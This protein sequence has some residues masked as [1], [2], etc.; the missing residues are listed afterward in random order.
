MTTTLSLL[1]LGCTCITSAHP[2]YPRTTPRPPDRNQP[3]AT[4]RDDPRC[5]YIQAPTT[6]LSHP[7][8]HLESSIWDMTADLE[9]SD[10]SKHFLQRYRTRLAKENACL[11]ELL[12]EEAQARHT[13]Q[14][15]KMDGV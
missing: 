3:I 13:A 4:D 9:N 5:A 8:R 11:A 10:G 6:V 2:H 12:E 7:C 14:A 15:A 1:L